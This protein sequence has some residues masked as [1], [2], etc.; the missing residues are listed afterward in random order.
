MTCG[1]A[2]GRIELTYGKG[3]TRAR[4]ARVELDPTAPV[5]A[6]GVFL[7]EHVGDDA[8]IAPAT[9]RGDHRKQPNWQAQRVLSLDIDYYDDLGQHAALRGVDRTAVEAWLPS[10]PCTWGHVTPRGARLY[11]LL[12]VSIVDAAAVVRAQSELARR[13][14]LPSLERGQL[15]I[16]QKCV[17]DGARFYFAPRATVD[18]VERATEIVAGSTPISSLS[19]LLRSP[20]APPPSAPRSRRQPRGSSP[21][22]QPSR[23]DRVSRA[24]AWLARADSA[25]SGSGGHDRAFAIIERV[26]RGFDL[27]DREAHTALSE[28]NA[29][30]LPP[31]SAAELQHKIVDGRD[32]GDTPVGELLDAE[33]PRTNARYGNGDSSS[34]A[35]EDFDAEAP[36]TGSAAKGPGTSLAA[37]IVAI[38]APLVELFH[39]HKQ[40][41]YAAVTIGERK[42]AIKIRS[43]AMRTWV[44]YAV[45][46]LGPV[47]AAALDEALTNLEGIALYGGDERDVYLRTAAVDNA[48][49]IDIG[50]AAGRCV[51]VT[52]AGWTVLDASPV[53]FR[54]SDAMRPLPVPTRGGNIA[55]LRPFVNVDDDGFILFVSWI[56]AAYRPGRPCAILA[57]HGE[58]GTA[59]ST[60]SRVGRGLVDPNAVPVRSPPK[61]EDDLVV[62]AS[63]SHVVA[64]DNLSGVMP[65]L[66]DALCRLA[67]GGGLTKRA[68]YT[69]DDEI[70]IEVLRPV[71]VNGID[72]IANRADLAERCIVLELQPIAKDKR[73]SERAF[74]EAYETAAPGIFGALLEGV[75]SALRNIDTVQESGLPRMADFAAWVSAAEEG[76]GF[77]RGSVLAAY[78][79]NRKRAVDLALQ[80][81]PVAVALLELLDKPTSAGRWEGQPEQLL[82]ALSGMT[83][84]PTR[85]MPSW[86]KNAASLSRAL[87]RAATFLRT[88]GVELDLDGKVGRDATKTRQWVVTRGRNGVA[89]GT[90]S[91]SA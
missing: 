2:E 37:V 45:R 30:C 4:G 28:W 68:L 78:A 6:L 59:K 55:A 36:A 89:P 51:K 40:V 65:W 70:V 71:I 63:H 91:V 53:M 49:Y 47:K 87:R 43:R 11:F 84:E 50:D 62:A 26:V 19:D 66:S 42:G 31:W 90:Q 38:V 74:R 76:L 15:V 75:V 14:V 13:L 52:A 17:K 61:T 48:I 60:T 12:D 85:R 20:P 21:P 22:V 27:S 8:W 1:A 79:R 23:L 29:R 3:R 57:L 77:E 44:S 54:R 35:D 69:D 32:R 33:R 81:S 58:Q 73:R 18:G 88:V 80:S 56:V 24:R 41:A 34:D 5:D 72:E 83:A 7:A 9:Y 25:I 82:C 64:Y 10:S 86:P 67:T 16:D 39:D 46:K